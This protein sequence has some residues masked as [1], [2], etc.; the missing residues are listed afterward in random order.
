MTLSQAEFADKDDNQLFRLIKTESWDAAR[1]LL[2]SPE[3]QELVRE[4]DRFSNVPLHS[5]LGFKAPDDVILS[6]IEIYPEATTV[7]GTDEWLPLHTAA[8]WGSSSK[9]LET[10]IRHHPRA[11][12]DKGEE[13][14]KG[15]TPRHF[16]ARFPHN[17]ELLERSTD[18]WLAI[19]D[20][21]SS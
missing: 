6:I 9:V 11:L 20:G 17:K 13:G 3:A 15:R 1:E 8:M 7:H 21:N 4:R 5:A 19:I 10:L 12:D 14:I 18:E 2:K 16:S